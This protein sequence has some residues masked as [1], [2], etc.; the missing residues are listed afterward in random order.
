MARRRKLP[1]EKIGCEWG[2]GL[3]SREQWLIDE[4][5]RDN[6]LSIEQCRNDVPANAAKSRVQHDLFL[7][8]SGF[9]D[10]TFTEN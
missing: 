6:G 1:R 4:Q 5:E 3:A 10:T 2:F 9:P 8:A 7:D